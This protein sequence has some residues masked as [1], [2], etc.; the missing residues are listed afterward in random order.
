VNARI[1]P[2][3]EWGRLDGTD[4]SPLLPYVEPQNIAV[5]VVEDDAGEIA[6]H[7]CALQVTHFEGIWVAPKYRGNAGVI[8][9]LLQ[10]AYTLPR[11]RGEHWA[12][13]G[14]EDTEERGLDR[15]VDVI[16]RRLGGVPLPMKL[17][18]LPV[19]GN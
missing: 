15:R 14:A 9:P 18:V 17:Y 6:A 7:W 2:V 10:L 5:M 12:F 16:I 4:L 19:K 1:L 13:T 11:S 8:R 3:E